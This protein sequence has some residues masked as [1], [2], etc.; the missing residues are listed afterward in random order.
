MRKVFSALK[1]SLFLLLVLSVIAGCSTGG[2]NEAPA[3]GTTLPDPITPPI[4]L[5]LTITG[6]VVDGAIAGATVQAYQ[7]NT[8]GTRGDAIGATTTTGS[9]G[10]YSLNLNY[11]GPV[12]VESV[13]GTYTDWATGKTVTLTSADKLT[14]VMSN[15]KD[16]VTINVTPLTHMAALRMQQ[17]IAVN[18]T[19]AATAIDTANSKIGEYFG[20][21]NILKDTPIDPVA[22]NSASG[23]SQARVDYSLILAG[24][25]QNA[26]TNNLNPFSLAVTLAKDISDGV[27]DGKQGTAQLT[28]V[29]AVGD[30][31]NNLSATATKGDLSTS[32]NTFQNSATNKSGGTI[33]ASIQAS[34]SSPTNNGAIAANPDTPTGFTASILSST[35]INLAWSASSGA[36]GYNI[37]G[38][39]GAKL[40][41]VTTPSASFAGLNTNTQYCYKI[42]AYDVSGNESGQSGQLCATTNVPGPSAPTGVSVTPVSL[43]Q[44]NVSW[45]ATAGATSYTIYK[46]GVLLKSVTTTTASDTGLLANSAYCYTVSASDAAGNESAQSSQFCVT[47]NIPTP[48]TPTNLVPTPVLNNQMDL[49]WNVSA[50]ATGYKIY[51][52]GV[53]LKSVTTN[54]LSDQNLTA[55]TRYCY[56]VSAYDA[57][58]NDSAQSA[59]ACATTDVAGPGTPVNFKVQPLTSTTVQLA[60]TVPVTAVKSY[61]IYQNGALAASV[62]AKPTDPGVINV[63]GL[64]PN[65]QY[66]YRISALDDSGKESVLTGQLCGTTYMPPPADPIAPAAAAITTAQI[67]LSWTPSSGAAGYKIYRSDGQ[68]FSATTA[69]FTNNGVAAATNYCYQIS[70]VDASGSESG[71]SIQ[72]CADTGLTVPVLTATVVSSTQIDLSWSVATGATGGYKVYKNGGP[73]PFSVDATFLVDGNLTAN[74]QYCYSVSSV[75]KEGG[76]ES[77]KSSQI[78]VTTASPPAPAT[79]DLLV[80][81]QQLNSDGAGA[82]TLTALV[83]D[84]SNLAMPGQV[85]AFSSASS[86]D[87]GIVTVTQGTTDVSGQA[88]ATL[89]TGGKKSY[90]TITVK[91]KA[92]SK[93]A[94]NTVEVV[95][96][97]LTV[98]GQESV[99]LDKGAEYTIMLKDSAGKAISGKSITFTSLYNTFTSPAGNPLTAATD[100]NGQIKV[101]LK[102]TDT[103]GRSDTL[104]AVSSEMGLTGAKAG[105]KAVLIVP[106]YFVFNQPA[107]GTVIPVN[108]PTDVQVEYKQGGVAVPNGTFVYFS[109]SRGT[110][111]TA[112]KVTTV[113]GLANIKIQSTTVGPA[114]ITAFVENGPSVQQA[115]E[116]VSST[117]TTMNLQT[118]PTVIGANAGGATTQRSNIVAVLRDAQNNFVKDKTVNF[119]VTADHSVGYLSPATAKT[120]SAGMASVLFIAGS[121]PSETGGVTITA[122]EPISGITATTTLTVAK[123]SLNIIIGTGKLTAAL[124]STTYQKDFTAL[125][126]DGAGNPVKDATVTAKRTPIAYYKGYTGDTGTA[127][128]WRYT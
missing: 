29:N 101:T 43:S 108:T 93:E 73:T 109:T 72:V 117:P 115:V 123:K 75:R 4:V 45:T 68:V 111:T 60:W 32:I 33:T 64:A 15:A 19:A 84:S 70:A 103:S 96:T 61:N 35:Q 27:F 99:V 5:T 10:H 98:S 122:L 92:G 59:P 48:P 11:N 21:I 38:G 113:G 30:G 83:K 62:N 118:D 44:I 22:S 126:T 74:T 105:A 77:A 8:N 28:V 79:I 46:G 116:F 102:A 54:S 89:G 1:I 67:T 63:I 42:S 34:L 2:L 13:G 31:T 120:D 39:D 127:W 81:S 7:I 23:V 18:K 114:T 47:T 110:F 85:V 53:Y 24:I 86:L 82:V 107:A 66:C 124:S 6:R 95:G 69:S 76:A 9:N 37:F 56:A 57:A 97:T 52:D 41:S 36:T 100:S 25:S 65:T 55:S 112:Y 91:A 119:T 128:G 88:I 78:C 71:K 20:G 87:P 49:S 51:R 80:S 14:A 17:E 3:T 90:R 40:K 58:S 121:A 26:S 50:G 16:A 12:L 104:T 125:V 106:T 94:E